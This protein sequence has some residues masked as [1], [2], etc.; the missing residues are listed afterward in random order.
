MPR[1][2]LH[3]LKYFWVT[4]N[5]IYYELVSKIS[6]YWAGRFQSHLT[7]IFSV[8]CTNYKKILIYE[9]INTEP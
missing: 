5:E 6:C 1:N 9:D 8:Y 2:D 3:L 4:S 7:N